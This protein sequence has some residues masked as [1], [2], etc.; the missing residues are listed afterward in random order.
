[1]NTPIRSEQMLVMV[2]ISW[3]C[4]MPEP[5]AARGSGILMRSAT[6]T[7]HINRVKWKRKTSKWRDLN[8]RYVSKLLSLFV[9]HERI[10]HLTGRSVFQCAMRPLYVVKL[11]ERCKALFKIFL[12][13]VINGHHEEIIFD[14]LRQEKSRRNRAK[15]HSHAACTLIGKS[16]GLS[17]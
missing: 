9:A 7:N 13:T 4:F 12:E 10:F 16:W 11:D 15:S 17:E 6:L 3:G 2:S 8:P 5:L 1:M 14:V